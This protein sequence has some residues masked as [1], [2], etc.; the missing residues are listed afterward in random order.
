[1]ETLDR[2]ELIYDDMVY[3]EE[4]GDYEK[5]ERLCNEYNDVIANMEDKSNDN[6]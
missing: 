2:A 4:H 3:A 1:M 6:E 5:A